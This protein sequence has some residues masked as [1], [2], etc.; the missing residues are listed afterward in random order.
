MKVRLIVTGIALVAATTLL[1]AQNQ[2]NGNGNGRCK[3]VAYV[4]N[5]NNGICDN[6]E[7]KPQGKAL[8]RGQGKGK[9]NGTGKG[10]NQGKGRNFVDANNNG[11]CDYR[12][13]AK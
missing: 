3:G 9:C 7:N 1:N 10:R 4:D 8:Q 11:V 12:E 6:Y 2:G 5:N 13:S